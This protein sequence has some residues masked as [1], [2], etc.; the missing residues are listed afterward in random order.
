VCVV[1]V[2]G[3]RFVCFRIVF[4]VCVVF[5]WCAFVFG[6]VFVVMCVLC[7]CGCVCVFCVFVIFEVSLYCVCDVCF[8]CALCVFV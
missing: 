5:G 1:L 4:V 8:V 7:V 3:V 6:Y 2:C